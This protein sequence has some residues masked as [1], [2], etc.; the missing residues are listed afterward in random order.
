VGAVVALFALATVGYLGRR[1]IEEEERR[2]IGEEIVREGERVRA[3]RNQTN[4]CPIPSSIVFPVFLDE[5]QS[6]LSSRL[7]EARCI[8]TKNEVEGKTILFRSQPQN[9]PYI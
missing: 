5:T 1:A 9:Q 4:I 2:A 7:S 3:E 8:D 6:R